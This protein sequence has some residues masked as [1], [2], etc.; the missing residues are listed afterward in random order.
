MIKVRYK[1]SIRQ[2]KIMRRKNDA[3]GFGANKKKSKKFDQQ[4]QLGC[5]STQDPL[6]NVK[7][8]RNPLQI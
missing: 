3:D 4:W 6:T 1:K 5:C 2:G 8:D 7:V